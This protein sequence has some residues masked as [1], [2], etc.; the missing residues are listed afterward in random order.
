MD[1]VLCCGEMIAAEATAA[2]PQADYGI[3]WVLNAGSAGATSAA[4]VEMAVDSL[5]E[6]T[7]VSDAFIND[8][9]LGLAAGTYSITPYLATTTV[10]DQTY[11]ATSGTFNV[12]AGGTAS[13]TVAGVPFDAA[14]VVQFD[15]I[16]NAAGL[17]VLPGFTAS[18]PDGTIVNL[19]LI[20]QGGLFNL[21][22]YMGDPNGTFDFSALAG[23]SPD[24]IELE[25]IVTIRNI[26]AGFIDPD[27]NEFG[28]PITFDIAADPMLAISG[29]ADGDMFCE[30]DMTDNALTGSPTPVAPA[31]GIFSGTGVTDNADGT[32][33]FNA[34]TAGPGMHAI[35][36]AYTDEFGCM[37]DSTIT[38]TVNPTPVVSINPMLDAQ[39]CETDAAVTLT[40]SPVAGA[41]ETGMFMGDGVTDNMD[42]TASFDPAIAGAGC[43]KD[44]NFDL[45]F[46]VAYA[47]P[48][49]AGFEYTVG[50]FTIPVAYDGSGSQ[51]ITIEGLTSSG[52]LTVSDVEDPSCMAS[53]SF[54]AEDCVEQEGCFVDL[55]VV[56][57]PCTSNNT[58][59]ATLLVEY[60]NVTGTGFS[61]TVN[62]GTPNGVS[63]DGTGFQAVVIS[64]LSGDGSNYTIA[65][66][67]D[68]DSTCGDQFTFPFNTCEDVVVD[69]CVLQIAAVPT[70]C[71]DDGTYTL[72]LVV[73]GNDQVGSS[74]YNL[75]INGGSPVA[76]AYSGSGSQTTFITLP[77]NGAQVSLQV[78]DIDNANCGDLISYT[79]PDCM[80]FVPNCD[81]DVSAIPTSCGSDGLYDLSLIV[82]YSNPG[83]SGFSYSVGNG[84]YVGTVAYNGSGAQTVTITDIPANGSLADVVVTDV[85]FGSECSVST[86][87][88]SPSCDC[89]IDLDVVVGQC[90]SNGTFDMTLLV[91]YDFA[92]SGSFVYSINGG[93]EMPVSYD[94]SGLQAVV[95]GGS[96][97]DGSSYTVTVMDQNDSS[98]SDT[99]IFS[100]NV[101][102]PGQQLECNIT[103]D[104]VM[105]ECNDDG[106]YSAVLVI[107]RNDAVGDSG[108][109]YTVNNGA[110]VNISYDMNLSQQI[111]IADLPGTGDLTLIEVEDAED[112]N[113]D[114][115]ITIT[116]PDCNFQESCD[117]SVSA[118]PGNCEA[119][120]TYTLALVVSYFSEGPSGFAYSIDDGAYTGSVAY[121]GSGSQ[122]VLI[123]GLP[124]DAA[125]M[126][127]VVTDIFFENSCQAT[128]TYQ[129]PNCPC[130][131]D[132]DVITGLCLE[133]GT[134]DMTLFV[135]YDQT[136]AA[137][138]NYSTTNGLS[139]SV[140]YDG[141]GFQTITLTG[142]MGDGQAFTV[143]VEDQQNAACL[144]QMNVLAPDC[145]NVEDNCIL[146]VDAI[147]QACNNNG[148]FDLVLT[149][150][151]ND[152]VGSTGFEYFIDGV[153]F[154][155]VSY[156]MMLSQQVLINGIVGDGD[157]FVVQVVDL[158][159]PS[160]GDSQTISAPDC[161]FLENCS[162][163]VTVVE[164]LCSESD[165]T[166]S[167][168]FIVDYEEVGTIGF[169]YS[170]DGIVQSVGYDGT[171]LQS[172]IVEGLTGSGLITVSDISNPSCNETE[173][174]Q[175]QDCIDPGGGGGG[176]G[177]DELVATVESLC[178]DDALTYTVLISVLDMN[179]NE[180]YLITSPNGFNGLVDG[181]FVDGPFLNQTGYNYTISLA[182][183]PSCS[184]TFS[185]E[186]VECVATS[187]ELL[188]FDGEVLPKENRLF[189]TTASEDENQYFTVQRSF[190]GI[191]FET[192]GQVAGSGNSSLSHDYEFL[193]DDIKPV[194][195][196]YRLLQ[197]DWDGNT[198]LA[199]QVVALERR[200]DVTQILAFPV[201]STDFVSLQFIE[202]T[203]RAYDLEIYDVM[204]K[205]LSRTQL[206][207][208]SGEN[209][210]MLNI[211]TLPIGTYFITL[212]DEDVRRQTVIVKVE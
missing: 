188:R 119:D 47:N 94:G 106:T 200:A 11:T 19:P 196:Y 28:T 75:I 65:I 109:N 51:T 48:G 158:D 42:G 114:F 178:S 141:S 38:V 33:S 135:S 137:G 36:Y 12:S 197:T 107:S 7:A 189:W 124:A 138:F 128:S 39:Y 132:V 46:V 157:I 190:D 103:I 24:P 145:S 117:L 14:T 181:T 74:G 111:I 10:T 71:N 152:Q 15:G 102:D 86:G 64:G 60:A 41:G 153:S 212:I 199:S 112:P 195:A 88:L 171:G 82:S 79:A 34:A 120:G 174:Y 96:I 35:T 177:C 192:I 99:F 149:I 67:D 184:M 163:D 202:D 183:D 27:C 206:N 136:A 179:D 209:T 87:Y 52:T 78:Q 108:F 2:N 193:D 113:C 201:P 6:N 95:V 70:D 198:K 139:G 55:D 150:S 131:I 110:V 16:V 125:A 4:D 116:A 97:G 180:Q 126:D 66:S 45:S 123:G 129:A 76:L 81:L 1:A 18:S 105:T 169:N 176:E 72:A 13:L 53:A 173:S 170:I 140:M 25:I 165:D 166:F 40:G 144:S 62:G 182:S 63:Y 207:S 29:V 130:S 17:T 98:C 148:T 187:I 142:N 84:N 147:P 208:T 203:E 31:T 30:E 83:V 26:P 43:G 57:G 90:L 122:S 172:V 44:D 59:S 101:C 68:D 85:F 167:V 118:I 91:E 185:S 156:D 191:D 210:H 146:M 58:F 20:P 115:A 205:L 80:E 211:S 93:V 3:Y 168:V 155:M 77:G 56:V 89:A 23:A 175:A 9:G 133:D 8:C 92:A 73:S 54:V 186:L 151:R 154:G 22:T 5:G 161:E 164:S 127:V 160:C 50:G 194:V 162:I 37:S 49:T 32:A 104:A 143:S 69:E 159:D 121:N 134:Y 61:Y 100:S 204:G 21:E